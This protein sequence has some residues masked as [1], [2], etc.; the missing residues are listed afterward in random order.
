MKLTSSLP[1]ALLVGMALSLTNY[2]LKIEIGHKANF[3]LSI[4][5]IIMRVEAQE[6]LNYPFEFRAF[7][8]EI[9]FEH[10]VF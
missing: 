5:L 2:D 4:A 6:W 9:F 10:M 8:V 3:L 7:L 1:L